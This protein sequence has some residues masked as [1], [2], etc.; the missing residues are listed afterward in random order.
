V[1]IENASDGEEEN[2]SLPEL[3]KDISLSTKNGF[4]N[5]KLKASPELWTPDEPK[6]YEVNIQLKMIR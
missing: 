4:A 2:I 5:F 3:R 1:K 6:L